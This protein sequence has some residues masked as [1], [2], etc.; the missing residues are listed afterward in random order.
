MMC[1]IVSYI[2]ALQYGGQIHPWD[3]SQVIGLLVGFVAIVAVFIAWEI[4]QKE[5]AMI[6]KRLVSSGLFDDRSGSMLTTVLL[7]VSPALRLGGLCV[8]V[9]LRRCILH[10]TLLPADLLPEHTQH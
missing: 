1:L 9:L 3:S 4:Y 6:V 8:H 10:P 5:R 7:I 2:L